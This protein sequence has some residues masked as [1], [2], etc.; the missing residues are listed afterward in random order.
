MLM[1][2][3]CYTYYVHHANGHIHVCLIASSVKIIDKC[4]VLLCTDSSQPGWFHVETACS[5]AMI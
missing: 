4:N 3:M 2:C 5:R 1:N